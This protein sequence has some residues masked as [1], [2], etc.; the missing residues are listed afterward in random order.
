[1]FRERDRRLLVLVMASALCLCA[2][3]IAARAAAARR[4]DPLKVI[5]LYNRFV[6]S[7]NESNRLLTAYE[8]SLKARRPE[9]SVDLGRAPVLR[10]AIANSREQTRLLEEMFEEEF[11]YPA[12]EGRR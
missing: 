11:G 1:M 9:R 12:G 10:G 5:P 7:Y 3:L 8:E 4:G 2:L 6:E